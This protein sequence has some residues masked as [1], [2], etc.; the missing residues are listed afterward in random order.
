MFGR[1][2]KLILSPKDPHCL[3]TTLNFHKLNQWR[4][5]HQ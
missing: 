3:M 2:P 5:D 1:E 4:K